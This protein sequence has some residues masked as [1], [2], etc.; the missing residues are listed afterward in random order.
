MSISIINKEN[1]D[2]PYYWYYISDQHFLTKEAVFQMTH[3]EHPKNVPHGLMF[4]HFHDNKHYQGQGSISQKDFDDFL[5]FVGFDRILDPWEWIRRLNNH[6]LKKGD[7]CL[8]LDDGLL[9]QFEIALPI[10]EKYNLKAFWFIYSSVFE[11][12]PGSKFEIYRVFRT[13]FFKNVDEFYGAFFKKLFDLRYFY[14]AISVLSNADIL[15]FKKR[16]PFY[17]SNDI[18]FRFIR[19]R[20]LS[21]R[22]FEMVIDSMIEDK[23][24]SL[25]ELS[26]DLWMN[27]DHLAYLSSRGHSIGLHSYSHPMALA[28]LSAEEQFNEF[29]KNYQHIKRVTDR[30][31]ISMAHPVNS[32]NYLTHMVLR[33]LGIRCGFRSNMSPRYS[34]WELN[35]SR[36][37]M[38]REDS[39]NVIKM[40]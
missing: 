40:K 37:E 39:S 9:C 8:T 38:A 24:I 36:H 7:L 11:G 31:P 29:N 34:C 13:K 5:Q 19:D 14:E 27:N 26:K 33:R 3:K 10:L 32:Y 4:H 35:R 30:I 12:N 23:G 6:Q 2:N 21:P 1:I 18:I 20:A 25:N 28:N 17:T 16:F 15:G 22:E